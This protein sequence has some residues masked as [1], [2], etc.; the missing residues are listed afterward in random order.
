MINWINKQTPFTLSLL[1]SGIILLFDVL[2]YQFCLI[3]VEYTLLLKLVLSSLILTFFISYCVFYQAEVSEK[4]F[5]EID[6]LLL[7]AK[8]AKTKTELTDIETD[9]KVIRKKCQHMGHIN[10]INEI[11]QIINTK[12]EY[13]CRKEY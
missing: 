4:I 1:T 7:R 2:L 5:K 3:E 9:Y 12:K 11:K 10:K 6:E 8:K 13:I